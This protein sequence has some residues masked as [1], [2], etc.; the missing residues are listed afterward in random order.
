[1]APVIEVTF[2]ERSAVSGAM[3]GLL[4][5][6]AMAPQVPDE[7]WLPN[8]SAGQLACFTVEGIIRAHVR[9]SHRGICHP[10]AVVWHAYTRWAAMQNIPGIKRRQR[11]DWPDGWLAQVPALA[12]RRGSAPATV[13]AL[14]KQ[15]MGT[16]EQPA[17]TSLG[18]HA[19]IR[20]LPVGL[21]P[22]GST[23]I[24]ALARNIAATTHAP[25][26]ADVAA[27]GATV[28]AELVHGQRLPE[29]VG[30]AH[31]RC[32]QVVARLERSPLS[33]GLSAAA[34][35]PRDAASLRR[36]APVAR[37]DC[38]LSGGVYVAASFSGDR[39]RE[40]LLF[41]ASAGDGGHVAATAGALMGAIHG[42]HAMPANWL[43]RLELS[44]VGDVLAH[45]L[46]TEFVEEPSG[47][48]YAPSPD[49]TWWN[50]YP[51]S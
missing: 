1:V 44:W 17:G 39:I 46:V 36:L 7:G 20:S 38:A 47:H 5:G 51:G 19:L 49:R 14:Q 25:A 16:V 4:L 33:E 31:D 48:E 12:A 6:D 30:L 24:P 9:Y 21:I 3:L 8:S 42:V 37:A 35:Q 10:P 27:L 11:E 15:T 22:G 41:A 43:S 50:R 29:A 34:T 18:A 23:D 26:A 40:A 2:R 13:S 45:E 32:A 28:I